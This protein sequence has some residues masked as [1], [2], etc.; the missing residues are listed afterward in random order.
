MNALDSIDAAIE[1]Q[2]YVALKSFE[3][4]LKNLDVHSTYYSLIE[5][6]IQYMR[7]AIQEDPQCDILDHEEKIEELFA[8]AGI[9]MNS[10]DVITLASRKKETLIS[11]I[12]DG[13]AK[14]FQFKK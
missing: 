7:N 14:V 4:E 12:G 11:K 8:K 5:K 1:N 6:N 9:D 2:N 3:R 10:P 13:V